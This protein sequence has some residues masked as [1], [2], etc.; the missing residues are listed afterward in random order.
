MLR[1][2]REL[3][4]ARAH[5]A[6]ESTLSGLSGLRFLRKLAET[7]FETH[8]FYL[9][10]PSADMVV[11]RVRRRVDSGGHDVPETVIRRRFHKS[12][13]NFDRVYRPVVTTWRLYDGSALVG[14]PLIANGQGMG[15]PVVLDQVRWDA[16]RRALEALP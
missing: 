12:M 5:L 16:F 9:W 6:F 7:G 1:R 3:A 4:T 11:A 14:R 10:L 2:L 15:A 13:M 8:I